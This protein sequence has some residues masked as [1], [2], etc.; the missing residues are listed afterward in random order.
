[1]SSGAAGASFFAIFPSVVLPVFLAIV[2]QTI[3]A[4]ALPGIAGD[5]GH[6]ESVAW[7]VIAYLIAVTISS[8]VYGRLGDMLGRRRLM[9]VALVIFQPEGLAGWAARL[10]RPSRRLGARAPG[11][12]E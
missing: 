4:T 12:A 10:R 5:L 9:F 7:V 3:V 2:D 1:M 6:V 11:P 8:P